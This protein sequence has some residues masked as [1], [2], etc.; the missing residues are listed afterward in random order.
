L[1]ACLQPRRRSRQFLMTTRTQYLASKT[2]E[3]ECVPGILYIDE[4]GR[5]NN[6]SDFPVRQTLQFGT[7]SD[8][9]A[10]REVAMAEIAFQIR[11][12]R[13]SQRGMRV[14]SMGY[15]SH[16]SISHFQ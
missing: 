16:R 11:N 14:Y 6:E 9:F 3:Q 2:S 5:P 10:S 4:T 15:R 12:P 8:P 1:Q 13:E 7:R